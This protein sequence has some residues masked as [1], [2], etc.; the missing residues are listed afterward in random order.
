[1]YYDLKNDIYI[2]EKENKALSFMYNTIIGRFVLKIATTK[3]IANIYSKYM[4][5][6]LSK[7]KIKSFI[8]KNGINI[9]EY[10]KKD[11][12]SFNDFFIRE[13]KPDKRKIEKDFIAVC[14]SKL[15]VYKIDENF[16]FSIKNSSYTIEELIGENKKYKYALIFRLCVDDYHHYVFP[17]SGEVIKTKYINGILHTVQPI[18]QK[19][20]KVFHENSRYITFLNCDNLGD[21]CYIEVGALMIGKIVNNNK[22]SFK[23][24]EEKG[25]FEFGGSTV[26][27][28]INEDINLNEKIIENSKNEIETIVKMGQSIG[29]IKKVLAKC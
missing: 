27:M 2:E 11:Y 1:M 6:K 26:I 22:K 21:V 12:T 5:S 19:K 4:N 14:D 17:D 28:L 20:Y 25:H 15:T 13:I 9:E 7:W 24:G 8:R 29:E 3:L 16:K 10:K 18:A 23:K